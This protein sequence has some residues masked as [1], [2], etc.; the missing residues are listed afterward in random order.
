MPIKAV[1]TVNETH[2]TT[3]Q[4]ARVKGTG[5][6]PGDVNVYAVVETEEPPWKINWDEAPKFEHIYGEGVTTCVAKA[7]NVLNLE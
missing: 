6:K 2:I 3:I 4:I 1:V 7:I 5:M